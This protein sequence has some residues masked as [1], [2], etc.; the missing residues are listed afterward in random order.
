MRRDKAWQI[1]EDYI[2][3]MLKEIDPYCSNTPGS[4]NGGCKGDLKTSLPIHFEAKQR[5]TLNVTI[6]MKVWDKM[7]GEVP[8]H[9]D[10]LP[11]LA[12][13][14]QDKRRFAVLDL[15]DFLKLYVEY[16]KLKNGEENV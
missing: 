2:I 10:K 6:M 14:N 16:H 5:D 8:F 12:L 11:V 3:A 4:G 13:E 9:V 1:F 15:D 7:L